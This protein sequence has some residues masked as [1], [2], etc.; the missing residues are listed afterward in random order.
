MKTYSQPPQ[1]VAMVMYA[2]MIILG[3]EPT[4]VS[5]KKEL[6]DT[7]FIRRIKG[8]EK[9]KVTNKQL[10]QIEKYTK[11]DNFKPEIITNVSTAAGKLCLWVR[12]IEDYAKALREVQPKREKRDY[13]LENLK[14]KEDSLRN[15]TE[16]LSSL[17]A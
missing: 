12:S 3:K 11:E 4:W 8:F 2:V 10:R 1:E 7:D 6:S 13:A 5:A 9:D 14:K 15:L 16:Q 17:M